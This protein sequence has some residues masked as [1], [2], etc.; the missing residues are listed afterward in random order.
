[1]LKWL[2]E[3]LDV[4]A[5]LTQAAGYLPDVGAAVLLIIAFWVLLVIARKVLEAGLK[6]ARVPEGIGI[7]AGRALKYAVVILALLTVAHQLGFNITSLIAGVGLAGLAI[8]LAAQETLTN[9]ISGITIAIDRPFKRGDWVRIGDLHAQVSDMRLRTT[10]FTTF[11]NETV[12]IPNKELTSERIVNYTLTRRIRV[13]VPV[14]I[15][16][17]EDIDAARRVMLGTTA[18]DSRILDEPAPVVV[19]EELADSSV[20][21][22]LRFWIEDPWQLLPMRY[23]YI[24]KCKKALDEA[25]IEIPFP[26]LQLF[27]EKSEGL[28]QLAAHRG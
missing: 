28:M 2:A 19:V 4:Q 17:K 27:L 14:G 5:L 9:I 21:L 25:G 24:E 7:L 23:E 8:S 1:M 11:D 22:E 16:Y 15:S 18:G 13:R 26:H 12:V 3:K 6:R 20:N 10:V